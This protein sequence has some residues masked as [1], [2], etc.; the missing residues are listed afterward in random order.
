MTRK[1][2]G[3]GLNALLQEVE[4]PSPASSIDQIPI[5]Q[6]DPNPLQPRQTFPAGSLKEL[7]D[8]IRVSGVVQP[9]LT[10]RVGARYQ[11][12]AGERRWRA[13]SLAGLETMPAIVRDLTDPEA[14][15]IALTENLLRENLNPL[16]VAKA[17]AQ[18]QQQFKLTHEEI[19]QRLGVSRSAVTNTLRLLDL[20]PEI[21][22]MLLEDKLTAGH[23][24]ALVA[25]GSIQLRRKLAT[26]VLK[27]QLSVRQLESLVAAEEGGSGQVTKAGTAKKLDPNVRAAVVELERALGTRVRIQGDARKGRIEISYYSAQDLERIYHIILR[28]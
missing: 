26:L 24:R 23:A 22:K 15:E 11:L 5:G 2:L 13:A 18:L 17:Y 28:K 19:A 7:A 1:A 9:V 8:S 6:I 12:I 14:L 3:R 4:A 25:T 21:Q 27:R 20:E 10:R 16:E